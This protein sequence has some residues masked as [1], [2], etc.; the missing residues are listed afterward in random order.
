MLDKSQSRPGNSVLLHPPPA[1]CASGV[2]FLL[3]LN[4]NKR[5]VAEWKKSE[6]HPGVRLCKGFV[7]LFFFSSSSVSVR[8]NGDVC[9]CRAEVCM[10]K[11]VSLWDDKHLCTVLLFNKKKI[12]EAVCIAK[13]INGS[14]TPEGAQSKKYPAAGILVK[15]FASV[16]FVSDVIR[17]RW[18]HWTRQC[19]EIHS[20]TDA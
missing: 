12:H 2:L 8:I 5:A 9:H 17:C 20:D 18:M 4:E 11:C 13:W 10:A 19:N 6:P 16:V 14:L 7:R 15:A 3:K 1:F